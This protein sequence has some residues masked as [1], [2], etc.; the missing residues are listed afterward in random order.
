MNQ[1]SVMFTT[2]TGSPVTIISERIFNIIEA[3]FNLSPIRHNITVA[4]RSAAI[5]L[6]YADIILQLKYFQTRAEVIVVKDLSRD[7]LL[8]MDLLESCP[9][10]KEPIK[11]LRAVLE[12][13]TTQFKPKQQKKINRI[14]RQMTE[15]TV[16][17]REWTSVAES[18]AQ[19]F[20]ERITEQSQE[21]RPEYIKICSI[22]EFP[23]K[24]TERAD[25][26]RREAQIDELENIIKSK[27]QY[28][29]INGVETDTIGGS[30][31]KAKTV[32]QHKEDMIKYIEEICSD[33]LKGLKATSEV[34]HIIELTTEKPFNERF[35]AVPYSKRPE[36][37]KLAGVT[38]QRHHR[39]V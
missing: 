6:G 27:L 3:K 23:T 10:T 18:P 39:G 15:K 1:K 8:G 12:G 5:I 24:V 31:E 21:S 38:G 34:T 17:K 9:L 30:G 20:F 36:F 19:E 32:K 25:M 26:F 37:K 7:C 2:D 33:G 14:Q 16:F 28:I 13:K 11:Q 4:N 22:D 29:Q 35:R